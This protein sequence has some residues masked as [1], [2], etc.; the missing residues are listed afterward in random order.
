MVERVKE[1]REMTNKVQSDGR[2]RVGKLAKCT[3]H[4]EK[5]VSNRLDKTLS[6]K[7]LQQQT[8]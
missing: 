1:K 4:V 8:Q 3:Y 5:L 6:R 2:S 7:L